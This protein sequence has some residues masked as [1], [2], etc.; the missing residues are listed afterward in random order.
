MMQSLE[1]GDV[2]QQKKI[3]FSKRVNLF[4]AKLKNSS[5]SLK[6]REN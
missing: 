2:T 3:S 6:N 4:Y 5:D 1:L